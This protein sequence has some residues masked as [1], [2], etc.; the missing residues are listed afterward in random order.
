MFI[1]EF[2]SKLVAQKEQ[3]ALFDALRRLSLLDGPEQMVA[4][5]DSGD[6]D[7]MDGWTIWSDVNGGNLAHGGV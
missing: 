5:A 3:G 1:R 2:H 7:T 4:K 6:G